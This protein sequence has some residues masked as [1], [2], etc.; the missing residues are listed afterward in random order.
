MTRVGISV[1]RRMATLLAVTALA[2][3]VEPDQRRTPVQV[4]LAD[5]A[6][7]A[8]LTG[9][10]FILNGAGRQG[11]LMRGTV[12]AGT[13]VL[14]FDGAPVPVDQDGRFLVA[15]DR[16]APAAA[17]LRAVLD[18]GSTLERRLAVLSGKWRIEHVDAS[19][20]GGISSAQFRARRPGELARIAAARTVN[21]PSH[22]WRQHF[23]WP[24]AGRISGVFGSQRI[25]RN[26]PG[27][28]HTG[29]DIAAPAGTP[30]VAPAGGVVVLAADQPFTLEGY[31]LIL[32]H[33][34]GLN[35]AFLHCAG[36]AVKEGDVVRAGQV[37]G[38]IGA[39]GR[40]TGPHLHWGVTWR[41]SRLDPALLTDTEAP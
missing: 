33:G 28:Y 36:L 29:V 30:F 11:G 39:S 31:L 15:F 6:T 18:D 1:T 34:M 25:Y 21:S 27:S 26:T 3:C 23:I 17:T 41:G 24:A 35:S 14:E 5:P 16:D 22:G 10:D 2:G 38:T 37:L 9:R 32:D 20:T 13:R 19:P 12:P 4:H 8:P 40:A 7:A